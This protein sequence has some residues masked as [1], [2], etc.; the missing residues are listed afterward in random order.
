VHDN[1]THGSRGA[2]RAADEEPEP[3]DRGQA[4]QL[5]A[6]LAL[7][8]ITVILVAAAVLFALGHP[9]GAVLGL[10]GGAVYL[11]LEVIRQLGRS[12][13]R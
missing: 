5:P 12:D 3:T 7:F 1:S 4:H 13:G 8:L 10:L 6:R 9:V 2:P 11:G